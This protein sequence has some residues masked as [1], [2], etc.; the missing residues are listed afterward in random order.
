MARHSPTISNT[1]FEHFKSLE[2][3]KKKKFIEICMNTKL[4]SAISNTYIEFCMT[5][6]KSSSNKSIDTLQRNKYSS[7]AARDG[8]LKK[9][10]L[11]H[12]SIDRVLDYD[13]SSR[14]KPMTSI[15]Y[16]NCFEVLTLIKTK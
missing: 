11:E 15:T 10:C 7:D 12:I 13:F 3:K 1:Y 4:G 14:F 5:T 16:F 8:I 2:I 9:Q 6:E